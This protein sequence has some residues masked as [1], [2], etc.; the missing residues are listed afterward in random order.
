MKPFR[1]YG[2]WYMQ[3]TDL[4]TE[5]PDDSPCLCAECESRFAALVEA[6]KLSGLMMALRHRLPD[7]LRCRIEET[8]QEIK[9]LLETDDLCRVE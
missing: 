6:D 8:D 2:R 7:S 3:P 9:E 5:P 4:P 1:H